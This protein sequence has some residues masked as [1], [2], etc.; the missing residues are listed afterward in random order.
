MD[1]ILETILALIPIAVIIGIRI[2]AARLKNTRQASPAPKPQVQRTSSSSTSDAVDSFS[3]FRLRPDE[4]T[5]YYRDK[6]AAV[7]KAYPEGITSSG[8]RQDSWMSEF[9]TETYGTN[10]QKEAPAL[11]VSQ[12]SSETTKSES[13]EPVSEEIKRGPQIKNTESTSGKNIGKHLEQLSPLARGIVMAELIGKPIA[14]RA[15][16]QEY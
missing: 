3:A 14:L 7:V 16:G 2:I 5:V 8:E 1:S 9:Q 4:E 10:T 11:P 15:G 12:S 13:E 6:A